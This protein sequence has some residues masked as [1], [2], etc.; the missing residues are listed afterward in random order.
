MK[1]QEMSF[2][3]TGGASGLGEAT[4]RALHAGGARVV[5]ADLNREQGEALAAELGERAAFART[6]VADEGDAV[7]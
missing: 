4:V 3:V 1:T 7:A 5:I 6:N 2:I